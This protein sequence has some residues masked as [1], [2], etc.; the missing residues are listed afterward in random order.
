VTYDSRWTAFGPGAK[1]RCNCGRP[2]GV[3][4]PGHVW[5]ITRVRETDMGRPIPAG[6]HLRRKCDRCG[7]VQDGRVIAEGDLRGA[8]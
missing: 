3:V 1:V 5:L 6:V 2:W 8:A 4:A 7:D